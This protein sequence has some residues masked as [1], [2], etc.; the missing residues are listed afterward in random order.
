M[1]FYLYLS[2]R[3][4]RHFGMAPREVSKN[5]K[6]PPV[7]HWA[8]VWRIE[9]MASTQDQKAHYFIVTNLETRYSLLIPHF[10]GELNVLLRNWQNYLFRVAQDIV[11]RFPEGIYGS[12]QVM[13]G[14][15]RELVGH[16]NEAIAHTLRYIELNPKTPLDAL[17][18]RINLM[19]SLTLKD[20]FPCDVFGKMIREAPLFPI[21]GNDMPNIIPFTR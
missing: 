19:P 7:T 15:P 10:G 8:T 20:V 18:S 17:E 2:N 9:L 3:V 14:N 13:R 11:G 16:M 1:D 5:S 21:D 6:M 12:T 4:I